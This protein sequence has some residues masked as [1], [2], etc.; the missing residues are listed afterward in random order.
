MSVLQDLYDSEI[1]FVIDTFWD[2]GFDL[3]LGDGANGYLA[4]GNV[5]RWGQVGP[6]FT[7]QTLLHFPDSLFAL[8]YRDGMSRWQAHKK[9][10][11]TLPSI[12]AET[13]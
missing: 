3:K 11:G 4:H 5:D 7:E 6:W 9:L 2:G 12:G 13:P 8:M 1:N 10:G